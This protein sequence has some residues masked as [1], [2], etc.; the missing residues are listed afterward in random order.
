MAITYFVGSLPILD[1][2]KLLMPLD[3]CQVMQLFCCPVHDR[4][5]V[6]YFCL[7]FL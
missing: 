5:F 3:I 7:N 1:G 4:Y 2:L 6:N